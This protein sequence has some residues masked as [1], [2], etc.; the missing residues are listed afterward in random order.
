MKFFG[1]LGIEIEIWDWFGM[2]VEFGIENMIVW[3]GLKNKKIVK[4]NYKNY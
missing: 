4:V 3:F 1:D 2:V